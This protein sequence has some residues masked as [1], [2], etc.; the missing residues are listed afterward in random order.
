MIVL[1]LLLFLRIWAACDWR[2]PNFQP[3]VA[4]WYSNCVS[5][6]IGVT[7]TAQCRAGYS[8]TDADYTCNDVAGVDTWEPDQSAIVCTT[9]ECTTPIPLTDTDPQ[10]QQ[11]DCENS[12]TINSICQVDC[13]E[14]YFGQSTTW[15][16]LADTNFYG[17]YPTCEAIT[18]PASLTADDGRAEATGC[19]TA[20]GDTC[21][22]QC[23]QAYSGTSQ[24]YKCGPN[25][26]STGKYTPDTANSFTAISC[27][28]RSCEATIDDGSQVQQ[29]TGAGTGTKMALSN[30]QTTCARTTYGEVCTIQCADGWGTDSATFECEENFA[31]NT[32]VIW[33]SITGSMP[34]C[35]RVDCGLTINAAQSSEYT[36][37]C[38]GGHVFES[39]CTVSCAAGYEDASAEFDCLSSGW[40]GTLPTCTRRTCD[41][42]VSPG[43]TV[44]VASY[45]SNGVLSYSTATL[46][47]VESICVRTA[48]EESCVVACKT[49]WGT[50]SESFTCEVNDAATGVIWTSST[51][52]TP[53]CAKND[54][55]ST[56]ANIGNSLTYDCQ[57][58]L[59]EDPCEVSCGTGYTGTAST[60]TCGAST[61]EG[62]MPTCNPVD[63]GVPSLPNNTALVGNCVST[64]P[65]SCQYQCESGYN[66]DSEFKFCVSTGQ[67]AGVNIVCTEIVD[68]N[69]T[70]I[71]NIDEAEDRDTE[72]TIF[73]IVVASGCL[74]LLCCCYGAYYIY[75]D[76]DGDKR[77]IGKKGLTNK[78]MR[79]IND[80]EEF[81]KLRAF[82]KRQ[83]TRM[84]LDLDV[85]DTIRSQKGLSESGVALEVED[86][87]GAQE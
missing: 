42:T 70:I 17:S 9:V 10:Y 3:S 51:G 32:G 25:E 71:N 53:Q 66:P 7:C 22:V 52:N 64:F 30:V 15:Q 72:W 59:F 49:G 55:G 45:D 16:C 63:C 78:Q 75:S 26:G 69:A 84:D 73:W 24:T 18:C 41:G 1:F 48:Y 74:A 65:N 80:L 83:E 11:A 13:A 50:D 58:T 62:T 34:T 14:G 60:Y 87:K 54:C 85:Q 38:S 67:W 37:D 36:Y 76:P 20:Y 61:W 43:Y 4:A 28:P 39:K 81:Q 2:V 35:A 82:L 33:T 57:N 44:Q 27:A 40:S 29:A 12:K 21:E 79:Q 6:G 86:T 31:D 5:R 46:S 56:I 77:G 8:G 68:A 19:S 23:K 47:E